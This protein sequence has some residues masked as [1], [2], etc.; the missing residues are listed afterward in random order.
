MKS[1]FLRFEEASLR[2]AGCEE[3]VDFPREARK[4]SGD[5]KRLTLLFLALVLG[6]TAP[7]AEKKHYVL[8]AMFTSDTGVVLKEGSEWVMFKGDTF[9]VI[10]FKDQQTKIV[11]Q[12]AGTSFMTESSHVKVIEEK[13]VTPDELATYRTNVEHYLDSQA[14][15]WKSE[16]AQAGQGK[17]EPPK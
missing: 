15:K 7:A 8:Y 10:M 17:V 13:D 9:P 1:S 14:K 12:L 3:R 16:Q 4:T 2:G 11:L 5:V 6:C